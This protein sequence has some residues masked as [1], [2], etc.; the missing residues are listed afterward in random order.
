MNRKMFAPGE[1]KLDDQ[2][3]IE[4]AFAQLN[5]I[6]SDGDVTVNGAFPTKDVPLSAY[7]H[8]SWDGALPV[9]KGT[10]TEQ[11]EWA[12]FKGSFFVNTTHGMDAYN[13]VKGLGDLAEYSY[14]FNVTDS[15]TG[16]KDNQSVRFI[17]S[18][19]VFEVSPVLKGAGVGTHTLAIKSDAP[20]SEASYAE[21]MERISDQLSALIEWTQ[22]RKAA[23]ESEGRD[24]STKDTERLDAVASKLLAHL[25]AINGLRGRVEPTLA[26]VQTLTVEIEKARGLGVPI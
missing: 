1:M 15:E 9:G 22:D 26:D 18:L 19:D 14:G 12:V 24:L 20:E 11:G 3:Y 10:I 25:D 6:D 7:G 5:V 4:A 21:Q 23:R 8:G 13:T 17:K 2:G 16:T